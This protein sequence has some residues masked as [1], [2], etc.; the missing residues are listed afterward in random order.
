MSDRNS[1]Q[2][3]A[4]R[5]R[6]FSE[7]L[8]SAAFGAALLL[9]TG[10]A[11]AKTRIVASIPDLGSIASRVGGDQVEVLT[12]ARPTAD[13]HR[14]EILP[15]YMVRVSKGA[16][17]L[18]VGLGLDQW[19]DQI[20]DGSRN[21]DLLVVDCSRSVDVLEKPAGAVNASM[22]DVHPNGNPHYW[23]DPRNGVKVALEIAEAL[24]RLDPAH[25]AEFTARARA[26]A[27][28]VDS[29]MSRGRRVAAAMPSREIITYHRSWPY[30]AS[31][32][33]LDVVATIEPVP[34]I[35]PTGRHLQELVTLIRERSVR[36]ILQEP[37]FSGEAG[38]F[39]AREADARVVRASPACGGTKAGDYLAHFDEIFEAMDGAPAPGN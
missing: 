26:F 7:R 29:T 16:V 14:V 32:F 2:G 38:D 21:N 11:A 34:G 13:P 3:R 22:G 39:L 25:A 12:I 30:F 18:K 27:A 4:P 19:A 28:D 8:A 5:R 31:A 35:P 1:I 17:Y 37:Y 23:L 24:G 20:I 6:G 36:I 10:P 15:S 9:V 33:G